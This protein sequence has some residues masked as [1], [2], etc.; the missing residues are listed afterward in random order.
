[1]AEVEKRKVIGFEGGR[2][3]NA[4]LRAQHVR[5]NIRY[6]MAC[7]HVRALF[8][9]VRSYLWPMLAYNHS[10]DPVALVAQR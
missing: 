2:I 10:D 1:M 4:V 7:G 6:S 8:A 5:N 3:W 9:E